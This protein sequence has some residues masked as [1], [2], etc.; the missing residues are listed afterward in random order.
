MRS[1][2]VMP[3]G[4]FLAF[5]LAREGAPDATTLLQFRHRLE[6]LGLTR[7]IFEAINGI[8]KDEAQLYAIFGLGN[9]VLA[10]RQTPAFWGRGVS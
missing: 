1:T 7:R 9:P 10:Q 6:R 5:T 4:S 3:S 2:T 8:A